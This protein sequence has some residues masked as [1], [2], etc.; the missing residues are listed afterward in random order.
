MKD[1]KTCPRCGQPNMKE[2]LATNALSRTD[3]KTFIC[4]PCGTA[5]AVEDFTTGLRPQTEWVYKPSK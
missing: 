4:D 1:A 3:N 5:E 2:K